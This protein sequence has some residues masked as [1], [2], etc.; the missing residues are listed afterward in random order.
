MKVLIEVD[1]SGGE[2]AYRTAMDLLVRVL[3]LGAAQAALGPTTSTASAPLAAPIP[4]APGAPPAAAPMIPPPPGGVPTAAPMPPAPAPAPTAPPPPAPSPATAGGDVSP[5][6]ITRAQFSAAVQKYAETYR[7]PEAKKR[8][9]QLAESFK[10]PTW[11]AIGAIPAAR[12]DD[13][14]PW[15]AVA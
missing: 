3:G 5:G 2:A 13:V 12:F 7:P 14:M 10:E 6:G 9:A 15:F 11:T 1:S 8:F 4:A